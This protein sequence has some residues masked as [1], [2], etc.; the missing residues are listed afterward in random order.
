MYDRDS[1]VQ[2]LEVKLEQDQN[3]VLEECQDFIQRVIEARHHRVW[4]NRGGCLSC[5]ANARQVATQ[6]RKIMVS[7]LKHQ[8]LLQTL[9][10]GLRT[11]QTHH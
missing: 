1:I 5:Y 4:P 10:N 7:V 6:T 3:K 2:Q 11:Y 9:P 8:T